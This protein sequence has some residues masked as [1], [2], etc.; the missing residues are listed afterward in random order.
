[1]FW[2]IAAWGCKNLGELI[3][4]YESRSTDPIQTRNQWPHMPRVHKTFSDFFPPLSWPWQAIFKGGKGQEE[5]GPEKAL[6]MDFYQ[7]CSEI[8][9]MT[10]QVICLWKLQLIWSFSLRSTLHPLVTIHNILWGSVQGSSLVT[11]RPLHINWKIEIVKVRPNFGTATKEK[12][13]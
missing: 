9:T 4:C 3:F 5:V 12:V 11:S 8:R 6:E 7:N 2:K 10:W 1:M 13:R